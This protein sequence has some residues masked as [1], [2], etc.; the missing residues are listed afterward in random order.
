MSELCIGITA[1]VV[2]GLILAA[3]LWLPPRLWKRKKHRS[4][5]DKG[6][7]RPLE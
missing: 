7:L 3:I 1:T 4:I 6:G 2:V 5:Y